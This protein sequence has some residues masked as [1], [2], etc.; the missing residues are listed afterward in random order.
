MMLQ[1]TV[2]ILERFGSFQTIVA[3]DFELFAKQELEFFKF[4]CP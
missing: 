4:Y 1:A 3:Y 2:I